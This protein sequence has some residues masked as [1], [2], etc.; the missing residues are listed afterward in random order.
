MV[1]KGNLHSKDWQGKQERVLRHKDGSHSQEG[2]RVAARSSA[3]V[4]RKAAS[5][6]GS[7]L[8]L[9]VLNRSGH[10]PVARLHCKLGLA[11]DYGTPKDLAEE[12]LARRS[13]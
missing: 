7:G 4:H 10:W 8:D 9:H 13:R 11:V 3:C 12:G 6:T 1:N 2:Q 5:P